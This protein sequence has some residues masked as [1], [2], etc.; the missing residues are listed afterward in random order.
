MVLTAAPALQAAT[1]PPL[2]R[3]APRPLGS[4]LA[5][6]VPAGIPPRSLRVELIK[7]AQ[8]R[9]HADA[10]RQP[11]FELIAP[12]RWRSCGAPPRSVCRSE[13]RRPSMKIGEI[14]RVDEREIPLPTFC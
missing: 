10:R 14:E 12:E 1:Q 2:S 5:S 3:G 9:V 7:E 4:W 11:V 13:N 8:R 6:P